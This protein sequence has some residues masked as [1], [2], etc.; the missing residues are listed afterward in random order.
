MSS[1]KTAVKILAVLT[2][3]ACSYVASRAFAAC[4]LP[5]CR[6]SKELMHHDSSGNPLEC[7]IYS[8]WLVNT[9]SWWALDDEAPLRLDQVT[10]TA[11]DCADWTE[12]CGNDHHNEQQEVVNC[13]GDCSASY[14]IVTNKCENAP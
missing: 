9:G 8:P 1:N 13:R 3:A 4:V 2:I 14:A 11:M 5:V 10:G 7:S 12:L 6:Q